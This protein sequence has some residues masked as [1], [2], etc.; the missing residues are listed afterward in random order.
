[1]IAGVVY[2]V[3]A[4]GGPTSSLALGGLVSGALCA[5]IGICVRTCFTMSR[6]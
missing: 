3:V 2:T 5:L 6:R 1:L 4:K